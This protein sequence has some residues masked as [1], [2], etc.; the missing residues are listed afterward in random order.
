MSFSRE[1]KTQLC[2]IKTPEC[3]KYA[4]CYGFML[5]GQAFGI[6]KISIVTE[7]EAVAKRYS[8][9]IKH[10]F[11]IRTEHTKAESRKTTYKV[12]VKNS[13]E[14]K[15]ILNSLNIGENAAKGF[16]N[17]DIINKECCRNAF[18]RG[19]F[20]GCG[21]ATDPEREYRIE[22]RIKGPDLAYSL[23]NI[24]YKK[25]LEPKITLK[26]LTNVIYIKKSECVEDFLTLIGAATLSL[27]VMD[28]RAIKDFRSALNRKS[29]FEDANT[30][31]TVNAS[32]EQRSAIEALI[33]TDKYSVLS[34][35]L[36]YVA[37]LRLNNPYASLS[38]L[39]KISTV[40]IT[41]SALNRRL[42]KIIETANE[43]EGN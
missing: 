12:Y 23:F 15:S 43:Q 34:E 31:K 33:K 18:L 1:L 16:I 42:K 17:S 35:E 7:N 37:Q 26:N 29:N 39:C 10:C 4:E 36:R 2:E 11:N 6:E 41:R 40:P 3:C 27:K 5:F 38:E 21:Q 19:M 25:E 20:L 24:L 14:R 30:S 9:L 22:F 8:Y 28:T 13:Y 32:V